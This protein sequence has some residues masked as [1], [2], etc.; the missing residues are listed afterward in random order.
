MR[1]PHPIPYQGSKRLL[2]PAIL[3]Y[4][5][6]DATRLLEPF[7]GAAAVSIAAARKGKA[8]RI[9]LNDIN[10]PL[11][12]LWR[13][14]IESPGTIA[15]AYEKLWKSQLG[16][17]RAYYDTVRIQFNKTQEPHY[18]LYLL[19]RC[20][21][22]SVRYNSEGQFNQSPD[23]RRRGMNPEMMRRHILAA[24]Q[25]LRG[26]TK[27]TIGD[28]RDALQTAV[29][30]DIVYM[31]PPYQ[32]VCANRDPR[33]IKLLDFEA[34]TATLRDLNERQTSYILS[35]DGRTGEKSYGKPLPKGLNLVHI[36]IDAGR[37]SQ[38]TLL[39]RNHNTYESVY[40]SPALVERIGMVSKTRLT[41]AP[42]QLSLMARNDSAKV[43]AKV[44]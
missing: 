40:L 29:P 15:I 14:I 9:V 33:Y 3:D 1:T 2:A 12:N 8:R 21:K 22:A 27:I 35:Y 36:E 13:A 43:S 24:S 34:F 42:K 18:L 23:N 37:S 11:M 26:K 44:P 28:Y 19:A 20:V 7:A 4:F 39:G 6:H 16:R 30:E 31:D 10:Q 17:E 25:L 41:L 32:G 5:P 38:A